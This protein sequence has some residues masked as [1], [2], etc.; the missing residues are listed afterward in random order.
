MGFTFFPDS[1]PH[2]TKLSKQL[3]GSSLLAGV[4]TT[5]ESEEIKGAA[6]CPYVISHLA[7][8]VLFILS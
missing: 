8:G 5:L 4:K 2:A 7:V 3:H 6:V 1:P